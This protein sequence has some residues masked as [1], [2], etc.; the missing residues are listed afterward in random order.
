M[1][2]L[3]SRQVRAMLL[4]VA[5]RVIENKDFLTEID[6][7]IGDGDHGIGME[8]GMKNARGKLLETELSTDVYA[9]FSEMGQTMLMSMGGA[10]GVIFGTMFSGGARGKPARET[11]G[12]PQLAELMRD[13]LT[14][15]KERGQAQPGDK[16]MVDAM[17]PAVEAMDAYEGSDLAEMLEQAAS[18]AKAGMEAT[19][20]L[21]AKFGRAKSLMGRE[22]GHQDAGATSTWIIFR[23]MEEYVKSL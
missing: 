21:Q 7:Q 5:D 4:Y 18:A 13:S 16:T 9:S 1:K 20:D 12:C 14:K 3:N 11:M 19:K 2:E 6:S 17:Q 23:S 15:I 22:L 8:R 10:S